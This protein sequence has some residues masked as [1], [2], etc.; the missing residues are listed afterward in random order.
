MII[1]DN[2]RAEPDLKQVYSRMGFKAGKAGIPDSMQALV[3]E[4]VQHG[5]ELLKPTGCY[6]YRPI[7]MIPPH[8]IELD[9]TFG[10]ESKK[11]FKWMEGCVGLY[12]CAVKIVPELDRE[13][14][15]LSKSGEVTRAFLLNAYGAEAAEALMA[16]LNRVILNSIEK[17]RLEATKR[18]SPG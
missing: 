12:L 17:P 14:A 7:R 6:D 9:K 1:L 2:L 18:Y 13:V 4:A 16:R 11:V 8:R 10:I 3:D 15:H 5:R